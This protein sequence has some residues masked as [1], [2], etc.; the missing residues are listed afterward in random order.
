LIMLLPP[1]FWFYVSWKATGDAFACF[2]QRQQYH[3]WLMTMNPAIAHFSIGNT[4]RDA[5]TLLVSTDI[6]V[7]VACFVAAR[8][9][10]LRARRA[11][12]RRGS[13]PRAIASGYTQSSLDSDLILAPLIFF[14]AFLGLL[15][16]A[17]LTH[18]QPIIFPRYG[19]ILFSLGL[20]ILAWTYLWIRE[21]KPQIARRVFIG[22]LVICVFDASVQ[23][24]G[25]VGELNRYSAQRAVADY[26]RDHFDRNSNAKIFCDE[27]TVRVLSGIPEEKFLSSANAPRDREAFLKFLSDNNIVYLIVVETERSTPFEL[28]RSAAEYYEPIGNFESITQAHTEFLWT[29]IHVYRRTR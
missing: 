3:D 11:R 17:Y 6:A 1:L 27:A 23:L 7:L 19:L 18:Q 8:L 16:L 13:E 9:L 2:R 29:S 4:L 28:F 24:A 15:L 10:I 21:H 26:L 25:A 20:S 14:F 22:I 5:A 12:H